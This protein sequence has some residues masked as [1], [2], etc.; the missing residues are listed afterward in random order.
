MHKGKNECT[1][2]LFPRF[3]KIIRK[4]TVMQSFGKENYVMLRKAKSEYR[5]IEKGENDS[6][7]FIIHQKLLYT[8]IHT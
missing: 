8:N 6:I 3:N 1:F 5:K 4:L 7:N 2:V